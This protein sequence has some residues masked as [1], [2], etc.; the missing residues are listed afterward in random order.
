MSP[1]KLEPEGQPRIL[2]IR[3]S[4]STLNLAE[5]ITNSL[6]GQPPSLPSLLLWDDRGQKLFDR[7]SQRPSYY[8]FHG[9]MDVLSQYGSSIGASIPTDEI[10]LELGC[11]YVM[12]SL[13]FYLNYSIV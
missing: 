9:E 12:Q 1:I 10:L 5:E 6:R 4:H 7:F 11:G 2:D 3:Q 8:P 13:P